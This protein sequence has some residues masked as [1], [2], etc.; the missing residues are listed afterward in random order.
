MNE[1][2]ISA[3]AEDRGRFYWWLAEWVLGMPSVTQLNGLRK[4]QTGLGLADSDLSGV[5][6]DMITAARDVPDEAWETRLGTE[7]TRLFGGLMQESGPPPPFESVW[8][9]DRLMGDSTLAVIETYQAAGFADI[10][11]TAG[12]QDHLGVELKFLSLMAFREHEAWRAAD[13]AVARSRLEQQRAFLDQ[14]ALPWVP[15]WAARVEQDAR[16]PLY[17][18]LARLI[19]AWLAT[20]RR[21]M[22]E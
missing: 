22:A 14:H 20:D 6:D 10:D 18:H 5:L 16:E 1:E 3:A 13:A 9:E 2:D 8:R 4:M 7:Y 11:P 12:P 21:A 19:P 17:R 15:R